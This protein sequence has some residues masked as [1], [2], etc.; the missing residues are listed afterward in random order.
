[1]NG[2]EDGGIGLVVARAPVPGEAKTRLA[3]AVGPEV[4]ADLAAAALLD[5]LDAMR[6]AFSTVHVSLGGDLD[7]AVRREEIVQ[8]LAGC[9][10]SQQVGEGFGERLA[11]AHA[12]AGREGRVV[13]QVGMDTPQVEVRQLCEV[14]ASSGDERTA[15]LGPAEDGGWWVL[16]LR[17]PQ[18]AEALVEV[19]MSTP[20]TCHDT[21]VALRVRGVDVRRT[22]GLR[23]V[24][25]IADAEAAAAAAPQTRFAA[26]WRTATP[27]GTR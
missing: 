24:D 27:V 4:A 6:S 17:D 22:S 10:V 15:V 26:T 14:V 11:H 3:A 7:R 5:T 13:V 12:C 16:A 23:D 19:P 1:M 25:E 9:E 8:A 18:L 2:R 21:E 20:T